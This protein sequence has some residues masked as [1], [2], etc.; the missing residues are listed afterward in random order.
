MSQDSQPARFRVNDTVSL[1]PLSQVDYHRA[2][3]IVE[4]QCCCGRA[5]WVVVLLL[6][7]DLWPAIGGGKLA[8]CT[9]GARLHVT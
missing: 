3:R 8:L 6:V 2:A 4:C 9:A 1:W 7:L 5:S